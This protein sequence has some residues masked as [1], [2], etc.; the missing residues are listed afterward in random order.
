VNLALG[1]TDEQCSRF[2]VDLSG[3]VEVDELIAAVRASMLTSCR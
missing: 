2:D 3:A 1:R